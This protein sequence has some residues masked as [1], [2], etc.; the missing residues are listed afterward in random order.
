MLLSGCEKA[1]IEAPTPRPAGA[2]NPR[3]V[4]ADAGPEASAPP[5]TFTNLPL[6]HAPVQ[7]IRQ[8][9]KEADVTAVC[10]LGS[11]VDRYGAPNDIY[12][13]F[14]VECLNADAWRGRLPGS[15]VHFLWHVEKGARVPAKHERLLVLLE[16]RKDHLQ[17]PRDV[18][19]VALDVGVFR[20]SPAALGKLSTVLKAQ[21]PP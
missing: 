2:Q 1:R 21:R 4:Q 11:L 18:D 17:P 20:L 6:D 16:R 13:L 15:T 9:S 10:E 12:H 14:D 8:L 3:A 5:P 7:L 19:W